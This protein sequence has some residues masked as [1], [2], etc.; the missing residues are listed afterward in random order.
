MQQRKQRV[1]K[2]HAGPGKTHH[3]LDL[4]AA[5]LLVAMDGAPVAAALASPKRTPVQTALGV[6]Q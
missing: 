2:Q 4:L 6:V 1:P 3:G 5:I